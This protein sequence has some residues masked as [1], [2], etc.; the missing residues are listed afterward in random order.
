MKT[1]FSYNSKDSKI[2]K[3]IVDR[4]IFD[5]GLDID[6][7]QYLLEA[8]DRWPDE[9]EESIKTAPAAVIF[10][11]TN[12]IGDWQKKEA[13][14]LQKRV[15]QDKHFKLGLCILPSSE[16]L[17]KQEIPWFLADIQWIEFTS[18]EDDFALNQLFAF[19][20]SALEH[21]FKQPEFNPK[22]PYKGLF[23][24]EVEDRNLFFGR[25]YDLNIVFHDNLRL[26]HGIKG[27]NFLAIV[28]DSGTGKSSFAKAG[29]LG[30]LK[31]GKFPGSEDWKQIILTPGNRPLV[32]LSEQLHQQDII[33]NTRAFEDDC[34][35]HDDH[36]GRTLREKL[37][38]NRN[39]QTWVVLVDQLEEVISQCEV[40]DHRNAF[41]KN[42]AATVEEENVLV[43]CTLRS[44]YFTKLTYPP[45]FY[46][47]LRK[48]N[49]SPRPIELGKVEKNQRNS[50]LGPETTNTN[51]FRN[52][53]TRP[54]LLHGARLEDTL[55]DDLTKKLEDIA[56]PL[57]VLQLAMSKLWDTMLKK[58]KKELSL[59]LLASTKN[60]EGVIE[61][62]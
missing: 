13:L 40:A 22:N 60:L 15:D 18:A 17:A 39:K 54:A 53:I 1:F 46:D 7:D 45:S 14:T 27:N 56:N 9:L 44:D 2:V 26:H 47:L 55:T 12:G 50:T 28:S 59:D 30:S 57:P 36:L 52:I 6:F 23:D 61:E 8:G 19:C 3:S 10:I 34:L 11:G 20:N 51:L 49:Y 29:I 37:D 43:I 21:R 4:L 33:Q 58:D 25:N 42:L 24:Y 35:Q 38:T 41:L 62:H 16:S 32:N 31:D 5:K 48:H